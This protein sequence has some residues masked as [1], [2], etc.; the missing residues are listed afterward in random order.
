MPAIAV[1]IRNA[2]AP[3][4]AINLT[5]DAVFDIPPSKKHSLT[6]SINI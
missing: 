2:Y 6:K 1:P 5:P 4:A 3:T